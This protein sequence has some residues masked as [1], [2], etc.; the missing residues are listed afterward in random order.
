MNRLSIVLAIFKWDGGT[1]HQANAEAGNC[2]ERS[3]DIL[4]MKED[5]FQSFTKELST[6]YPKWIGYHK[7]ENSDLYGRE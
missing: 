7:A 3:V 2:L 4:S 5:E 1:I 6:C